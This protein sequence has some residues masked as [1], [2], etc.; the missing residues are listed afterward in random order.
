MHHVVGYDL[1]V[2]PDLRVK[3]EAYYQYL[4]DVPVSANPGST[5]SRLNSEHG[6]PDSTLQNNG[7]GYNKGIELTVEKF[8]ADN[9]YFLATG[10]AF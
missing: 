9:Y 8:Y 4:Y 5:Y 2:R 7:K 1:S 10:S 3:V 6:I